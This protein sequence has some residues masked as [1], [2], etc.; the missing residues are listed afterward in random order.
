[1]PDQEIAGLSVAVKPDRV[2]VPARIECGLPDLAGELGIDVALERRQRFLR[3]A[4]VDGGRAA[5]KKSCS[6]GGGPSVASTWHKAARKPARSLAN[7]VRLSRWL[8]SAVSP[9]IQPYRPGPGESAARHP[10]GH[11]LGDGQR[12]AAGEDRKPAVLL[13]HLL[14]VAL[15][16]GGD[17]NRTG[18]TSLEGCGHQAADLLLPRSGRPTQPP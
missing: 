8:T 2:A 13:F 1:V 18:M 7:C 15:S 9:S 12:Q 3:L 11:R 6:P 4:V 14:D 10:L 16:T 5:E 17:R